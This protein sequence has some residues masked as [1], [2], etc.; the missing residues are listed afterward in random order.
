MTQK[1]KKIFVVKKKQVDKGEESPI[2]KISLVAEPPL[3]FK[4]WTDLMYL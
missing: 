3:L 2:L 4:Y 1:L